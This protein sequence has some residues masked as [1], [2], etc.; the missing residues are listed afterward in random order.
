MTE[1]ELERHRQLTEE[2]KEGI[3]SGELEGHVGSSEALPLKSAPL[4]DTY[5]HGLKDR[6]ETLCGLTDQACAGYSLRV[7]CDCGHPDCEYPV[8]CPGCLGIK[9]HWN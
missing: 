4:Y 7:A 5:R 8:N 2:L 3:R 6:A 9:S 1:D